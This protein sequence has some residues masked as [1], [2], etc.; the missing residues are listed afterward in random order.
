MGIAE[1]PKEQ[2]WISPRELDYLLKE[3]KVGQQQSGKNAPAPLKEMMLS[4]PLWSC[5]VALCANTFGF[6]IIGLTLPTF[7]D[8]TLHY[9]ILK[10]S[11]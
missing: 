10:V 5:H 3:S 4:V 11:T 2:R 1:D 7:I 6:F 9:G 8:K